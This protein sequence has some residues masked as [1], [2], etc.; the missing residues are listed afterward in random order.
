MGQLIVMPK[1]GLTMTK[2][3]LV[4][5]FKAE[6]DE[7]KKGESIFSVETDKLTNDI[8]APCN[9]I[10]RKIIVES[11]TKEVLE[12]VGIIAG[13]DEDISELLAKASVTS[14]LK[15]NSQGTNN[16]K[17]KEEIVEKKPVK[18][19]GR[20]K[21][22]P[23]AKRLAKDEGINIRLVEGTGPGG[24]I[25]E[26]DVLNYIEKQSEATNQKVKTSPTADKV[27]KDLGVD[28]NKISKDDRV[29]KND[30]ID[31]WN[32]E[33]VQEMANPKE[34]VKEM[35]TMRQVIANR[36]HAS[37]QVTASVHYN[38]S[39]DTTEMQNLRNQLKAFYK[40]TYTDI[41][42][43]I[44][45]KVLLEY[46]E[47]NASIDDNQIITRN[48]ANIGV[49]VAKPDGL[50]VPVVKYANVK[51]IKNISKEIKSLAKKARNNALQP[52]EMTGGTFTI[53]NLGMYGMESFTP[54]INHP[55]VAILGINTIK[56]VAHN[57]NGELKFKPMMTLS[58]T[59]DHRVVDGSKAAEFLNRLKEYIE[60][61][62]ILLL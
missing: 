44:L 26:E 31:Y 41:L 1:L 43:K 28:I 23:K 30:V 61:P 29:M 22:S 9:G 51:G 27:A 59:A 14:E 45:S 12:P 58:L 40:V 37:Q 50:I 35:S 20:V 48:Y 36:M 5:W 55:E 10:L 21:A 53:S 24:V 33:R 34:N 8:E 2:G 47:L 4:K 62:S 32:F 25:K 17:K 54:I 19:K 18:Q 16:Q 49:A 56:D 46:P 13:A 52:D 39:V 60:N 57:V 7:I 11:G 6:G 42:V 38:L 3:N 15:D